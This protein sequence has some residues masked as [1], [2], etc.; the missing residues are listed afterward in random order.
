MLLGNGVDSH[1]GSLLIQR[2]EGSQF[3]MF[4][5]WVL[6]CAKPGD[7]WRAR[8]RNVFWRLNWSPK[9]VFP[10]TYSN[11]ADKAGTRVAMGVE[12]MLQS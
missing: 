7:S 5:L 1:A 12:P 8:W 2:L 11:T 9:L 3:G 4:A 6:N 10:E